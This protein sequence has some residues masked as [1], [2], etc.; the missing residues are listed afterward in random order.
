MKVQAH[1]SIG[2]DVGVA[3]PTELQHA[4]CSEFALAGCPSRHP[5]IFHR[6]S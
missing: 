5:H 4:G 3:G 6:T 1:G 2:C